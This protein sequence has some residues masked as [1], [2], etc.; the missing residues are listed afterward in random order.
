MARLKTSKI[1]KHYY[2]MLYKTKCHIVTQNNKDN[3]EKTWKKKNIKKF[4]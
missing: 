4:S 1:L 2:K 3:R